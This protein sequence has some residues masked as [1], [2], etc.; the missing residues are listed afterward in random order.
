LYSD[1]KGNLIVNVVL[2]RPIARIVRSYGPS[3]YIAEDGAIM[4]V[5][6]KFSTRTLL[7]SGELANQIMHEENILK[8]EGGSEFFYMINLIRN[9]E[10]WRAQIA[11]VD[12][13]TIHKTTLY[14]Q[15]GGQ[16]IEFGKLENIDAKFSKLKVFY[17]EIL[18]QKGWNTYRR[19]N[20]EYDGQIVTE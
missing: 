6:E 12:F 17:K 2:R 1:I 14:P 7:I 18:P 8:S 4:P 13:S 3:V 10:F 16:V 20:L 9:D 19:V 11:Q 15:I 5:S